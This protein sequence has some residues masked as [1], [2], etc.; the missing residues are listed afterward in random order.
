MMVMAM[1]TPTTHPATTFLNDGEYG[2]LDVI[3]DDEKWR[4]KGSQSKAAHEYHSRNQ[5]GGKASTG[6]SEKTHFSPAKRMR[7]VFRLPYGDDCL[8]CRGG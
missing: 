3:E 5:E 1:P 4:E 7:P 6:R 2:N 8:I